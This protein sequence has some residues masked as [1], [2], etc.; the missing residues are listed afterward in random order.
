[1][2]DR[3]PETFESALEVSGLEGGYGRVP[4]LRG[5]SFSIAK[6]ENT[7]LIGPNGHGKTT[8]FRTLAGLNKA[9]AGTVRF[10][11]EDITNMAPDGVVDRGLINVAQGNKLFPSLSVIENLT[12]GGYN[13]RA[14]SVRETMLADVFQLFPRLKE[15][16]NQKCRS[17][18]GG[19]RQMVSIGCGLMASPRMLVLDEPTLGLSPKL[20]SEL[21]DAIGKIV[22]SGVQTIIVEQD[23]EF[24]RTLTSR[25]L[26]VSE[27]IVHADLGVGGNAEHERIR[28]L[29]FGIT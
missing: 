8:L 13:K 16:R 1:M 18:S 21:Q 25:L 3:V 6:G 19:E 10:F 4:V 24:L 9:W 26:L 23:P 17:L 27:G 11:G 5:I 15:R 29:Y 22:A 12:L 7:G 20:K 2:S 14:R 28:E